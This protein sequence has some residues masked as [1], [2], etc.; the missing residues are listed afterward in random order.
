MIFILIKIIYISLFTAFGPFLAKSRP[1]LGSGS[2]EH[3]K[4][5]NIKNLVKTLPFE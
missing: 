2:I 1:E 5:N 3:I 4:T